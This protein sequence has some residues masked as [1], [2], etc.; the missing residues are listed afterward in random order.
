MLTRASNLHTEIIEDKVYLFDIQSSKA[1]DLNEIA[2]FI[3]NSIESLSMEQMIQQLLS[4]YDIDE[5]QLRNDMISFIEEGKISG[6]FI[7]K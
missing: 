4:E 5:I 6:L 2:S 3:W 1:T 7:E